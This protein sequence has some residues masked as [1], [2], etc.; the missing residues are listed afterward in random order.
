M[1]KLPA[2]RLGIFKRYEE[3]LRLRFEVDQLPVS[4]I[5]APFVCHTPGVSIIKNLW[6]SFEKIIGQPYLCCGKDYWVSRVF[7]I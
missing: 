4:G 2:P 3:L 7:W 5:R 6:P 1:H